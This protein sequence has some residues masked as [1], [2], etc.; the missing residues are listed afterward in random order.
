M[1]LLIIT[2]CTIIILMYIIFKLKL[3][4]KKEILQQFVKNGKSKLKT[5][6]LNFLD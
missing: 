6:F 2:V 3:I 5:M 4:T 1:E